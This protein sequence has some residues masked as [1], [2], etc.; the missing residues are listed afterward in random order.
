MKLSARR[1][2][3]ADETEVVER[4]RSQLDRQT[5]N[6][7]QRLDHLLAHAGESS[8]VERRRVVRVLDGFQS[9]QDRGELLAGLIVQFA[10]EPPPFELLR[11]DD[12]AQRIAWRR[13]VTG[14]RRR[15]RGGK[16]LGEAKIVV[17]EPR[18]VDRTCRGRR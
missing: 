3:A 18:V 7:M 4:L 6:V 13:G 5:P 9:E 15:R 11:L 14:R 1:S 2:T 16:G 8:R 10:R 17:G 12:S